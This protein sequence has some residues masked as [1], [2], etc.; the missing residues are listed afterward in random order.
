MVTSKLPNLKGIS[1]EGIPLDPTN[2]RIECVETRESLKEDILNMGK[3]KRKYMKTKNCEERRYKHGPVIQFSQYDIKLIEFERML[4]MAKKRRSDRTMVALAFLFDETYGTD[5]WVGTEELGAH[6]GIP[7]STASSVMTAIDRK[8]G[9]FLERKFDDRK[10]LRKVTK[11]AP[12]NN[13]KEFVEEYYRRDER[14]T[15]KAARRKKTKTPKVGKS[16]ALMHGT[17]MFLFAKSK[18]EGEDAWVQTEDVAG[19]LGVE[20]R[21]A[22]SLLSRID[23]RMRDLLDIEDIGIGGSKKMRRKVSDLGKSM[24]SSPKEFADEFYT[25]R[26]KFDKPKTEAPK[27]EAEAEVKPELDEVE[28]KVKE[29]EDE[30]K[31][32]V[33]EAVGGFTERIVKVL[34]SVDRRIDLNLNVSGEVK[35]RFLF[36]ESK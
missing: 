29:L 2:L 31:E 11:T 19:T 28:E 20:K 1:L 3:C 30:I 36:G 25:R 16:N 33:K 15:K 35:F 5:K 4:D 8:M 27:V 26:P 21:S 12:F 7:R 34:N 32:V 10:I 9:E 24:F 6:L 22:S 18:L 14:K 23:A 13:A 17:L